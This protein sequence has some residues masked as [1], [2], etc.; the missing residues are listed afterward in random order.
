MIPPGLDEP[1]DVIGAMVGVL[2]LAWLFL[3][4]FG[5]VTR[6]TV[7]IETSHGVGPASSGIRQDAVGAS[8]CADLERR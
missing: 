6:T 5:C 3:L 4:L 1:P 8:V 2:A 7:C